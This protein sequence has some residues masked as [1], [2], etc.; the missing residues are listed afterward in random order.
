MAYLEELCD[1][2][3]CFFFCNF[4]QRIHIVVSITA[5]VKYLA[6]GSIPHK[7]GHCNDIAENSTSVGLLIQC[8]M[9]AQ[10]VAVHGTSMCHNKSHNMI[11]NRWRTV[12]SA[13]RKYDNPRLNMSHE[14]CAL[15]WHVQPRV[16]IF[17]CRT[18]YRVSYVL[19]SDQL[20]KSW[21]ICKLKSFLPMY[22]HDLNT[23]GRRVIFGV[24]KTLCD[25]GHKNFFYRRITVSYT[26]LTLP[27]IYSV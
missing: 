14:G 13:T 17:P 2:H 18:N 22:L 12:V 25:F 1:R 8:Q 4:I 20:Q 26:H 19:S 15:V 9:T 11:F 6:S 21:I 23:Q 5:Y 24:S 16:V 7:V 27:T 10:V 3:F